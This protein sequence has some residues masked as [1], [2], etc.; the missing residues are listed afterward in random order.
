M[1]FKSKQYFLYSFIIWTVLFLLLTGTA[2]F[3]IIPVEDK[4]LVVFKSSNIKGYK[5]K[6]VIVDSL[7]V[8]AMK[9]INSYA[10][11]NNLT[12]W[13]TS[14][15]RKANQKIKGA[16]VTPAVKSNHL[17]GHAIDMNI[18]YKGKWYDSHSMKKNRYSK[19]PQNI[20][21]FFDDIRKD[22]ELRWGGDFK[23]Q[24]PVHIDD[25]LNKNLSKWQI[26]FEIC[27]KDYNKFKK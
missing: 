22:K 20:K 25:Y 9:R 23:T 4:G 26:R 10:K 12:I 16:I 19:L 13:V 24:D 8:P 2:C 21:N 1:E 11:S 15:F 18:E 6:P 27:Q 5:N 17:A 3:Y 7:F 14:S